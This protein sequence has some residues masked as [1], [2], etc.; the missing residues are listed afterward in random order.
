MACVVGLMLQSVL[1]VS[2]GAGGATG[3]RGSRSPIASPIP[4]SG[5]PTPSQS[6]PP[7]VPSRRVVFIS[8]RGAHLVGRLFSPGGTRG[9]ILAH[10]VDDDQTDWLD[11]APVLA[12]HDFTVL[13]FNFEGY[14]GGGGCSRGTAPSTE[15]WTDIVG[16]VDF[17]ETKGVRQIGLLGASLGGEVCMAAAAR[18]G[19]RIGAVATLSASI[20]LAEVGVAAARRDA[21]AI[22]V[23]KLFVSGRFDTAPAHAARTFERVAEQPKRLVLLPSGEHGIDLLRWEPGERTRSL[24]LAFFDRALARS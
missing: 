3:P 9:V 14:C 19:K 2:C 1:A 22:T 17:L 23:P 18:L 5:G 7:T 21:S 16:A 6:D 12:S 13:T 20:G 10:Q 24:I 8:S 4:T 11:F 15:L